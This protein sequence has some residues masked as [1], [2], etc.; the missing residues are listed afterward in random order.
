MRVRSFLIGLLVGLLL[1][2]SS[3]RQ[4]WLQLR[5]RLAGTIDALLRLAAPAYEPA[6][7]DAL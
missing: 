7:D 4:L 2:P 5:N 6:A 3:G 1:A